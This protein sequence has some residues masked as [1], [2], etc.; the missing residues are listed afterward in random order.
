MTITLTIHRSWQGHAILTRLHAL[1]EPRTAG[2]DADDLGE[3]FNGIDAPA[4]AP[5][6][7]LVSMPDPTIAAA[8]AGSQAP[9]RASTS[10][11]APTSE[12]RAPAPAPPWC[13]PPQSGQALYRWACNAKILPRVNA[14]GKARGWHRLVTHWDADQVAIAYRELTEGPAVPANG[15]PRR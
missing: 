11:P 5:P 15:R 7:A 12:P 1:E 14:I 2:D 9:P 13:G 3:L 6:P 4:P 10:A 8:I